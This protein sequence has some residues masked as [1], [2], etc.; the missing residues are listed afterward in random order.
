MYAA[1]LSIYTSQA[2]RHPQSLLTR[3]PG[4]EAFSM[5][6]MESDSTL[7]K[8]LDELFQQLEALQ[9]ELRIANLYSAAIMDALQAGHMPMV[10]SLLRSIEDRDGGSTG[11]GQRVVHY[12]LITYME[13]NPDADLP[14]TDLEALQRGVLLHD[15][16]KLGVPNGIL[17]KPG[18]LTEDEWVHVK[19]HPQYGH[20]LLKSLPIPESALPVVLYHHEHY[21][22]N[23]Y[24][25]GAKGEE[26]PQAARISAVADAFDAITS[27]R[28]YRKAQSPEVALNEITRCSG[29]HFDPNV[30]SAF[31]TA[32][33]KEGVMC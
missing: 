9:N 15:I 28:P 14:E 19:R 10:E 8:T 2:H 33:Q 11:H 25:H 12:F 31:T 1:I 27:D 17:R 30:V 23:G 22:G 7:T 29:T 32:L 20:Q 21:D 18:P 6:G 4:W 16:G 3:Q 5:N 13:M 24:P 26:I